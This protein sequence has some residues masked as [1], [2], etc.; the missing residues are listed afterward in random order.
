[1]K[2]N[3]FLQRSLSAIILGPIFLFSIYWSAYSY[4]ILFAI[5]LILGLNEFYR[6]FKSII[7]EQNRILGIL[8]SVFI[9]SIIFFVVSGIIDRR[10]LLYIPASVL[11]F[12]II[13]LYDR[14]DKNIFQKISILFLGL[15]YL[16][17]PLCTMHF[18]VYARGTYNYELIF[19]VL[20]GVWASDIGGYIFGS[21]LGK[22]KLFER[23]SKNKTWEGVIGG[24]LFSVFINYICSLYFHVL[25]DGLWLIAGI[26][27]SVASVYGDLVESMLKRSVGVK[28]SGNIIPGH[29]GILDRFDSFLF[30]IVIV[31]LYINILG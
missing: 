6:M 29:G 26:I 2:K 15:L 12:F 9:Y 16:A 19:V 21:I 28:D 5:I 17:V 27:I 25:T 22:H 7:S 8:L 30:A 31:I 1:M 3:N 14:E 20:F 13:K 24:I 10:H 11:L 18:G 23:I 4:F